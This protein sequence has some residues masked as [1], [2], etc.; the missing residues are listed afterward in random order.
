MA[1]AY[2]SNLPTY[3][4]KSEGGAQESFLQ[5]L[6]IFLHVQKISCKL[7][8]VTLILTIFPALG[9]YIIIGLLILFGACLQ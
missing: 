8:K 1:L 9:L 7:H 2:F 4:G 6:K 5:K 3:V